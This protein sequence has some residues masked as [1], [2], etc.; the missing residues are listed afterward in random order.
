DRA[1]AQA[2]QMR[3]RRPRLAILDRRAWPTSRASLGRPGTSRVA[4]YAILLLLIAALL[5]VAITVGA[6]WLDREH[7]TLGWAPAGSM[8]VGRVAFTATL[9]RDGQVLVT[10]GGTTEGTGNI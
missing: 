6:R 4:T 8:A 5:T 3:Q 9:L 2:R 10:G 1:I 7:S